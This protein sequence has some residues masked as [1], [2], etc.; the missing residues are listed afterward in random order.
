[1]EES[2]LVCLFLSSVFGERG[3]MEVSST[4]CLAFGDIF[5]P[6]LISAPSR[7]SSVKCLGL[8]LNPSMWMEAHWEQES[9]ATLTATSPAAL[10]I[11][12]HQRA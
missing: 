7:M 1:M 12:R 3:F 8:M 2:L 6:I 11:E 10:P 9:N 5:L 4:P